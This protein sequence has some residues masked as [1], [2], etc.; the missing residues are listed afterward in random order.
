MEEWKNGRM[1]EWKNGRMEEWKNGRRR[2][3]KALLLGEQGL[4]N[5]V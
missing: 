3:K 4:E 1:E 5:L 2:T